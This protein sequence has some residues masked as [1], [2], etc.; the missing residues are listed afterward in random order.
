[1][2]SKTRI[3]DNKPSGNYTV[4]WIQENANKIINGE[5]VS[6]WKFADLYGKDYIN[7]FW[8]GSEWVESATKEEIATHNQQ[9]QLQVIEAYKTKWKAD[10]DMYYSDMQNRIIMM[11][12]GKVNAVSLMLEIKKTVNPMLEQI[13]RGNQS[14]AMLDYIDG[15]NNPTIKDVQ[16]LFNEI[17]QYCI[18]YYQ[19]EYPH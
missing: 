6:E 19:T 7:P 9:L 17:G 2:S 10:G 14:L 1:M 15:E 18:S 12:V 3:I 16:D 5:L 4:D 11:L 13:Q 8:N